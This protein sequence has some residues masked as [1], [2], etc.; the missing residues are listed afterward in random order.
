MSNSTYL[1]EDTLL[2]SAGAR[3]L[4]YILDQICVVVLIFGFL[5]VLTIVGRLV[6]TDSV[7]I[8]VGGLGDLGWNLLFIVGLIVYY[9]FMEGL[10]G[11]TLAKFV[12]GSV[13][14][15]Q[16]G[17]KPDLGTIA[18]RTFCRCI[19]F[20]ALTFLGGSRGWHDSISDTYVV[21]KK[22]LDESIKSFHDFNLIGAAETELI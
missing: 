14:V 22:G 1:L 7:S 2:V 16:N 15:D 18:K 10:F 3:F 4:N 13:V 20:D 19:P 6:G 8:W 17:E 5:I 21:S 9:I 12:T 11:R